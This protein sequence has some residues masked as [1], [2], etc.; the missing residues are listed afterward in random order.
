MKTT[1]TKINKVISLTFFTFYLS[2]TAIFAQAPEKMTY[3]AVIRNASNQLVVNT[4]IGMQISILQTSASGTAVYVETQTQSTNENGVVTLEIGGGNV[5]SGT[6]ANIDWANGIYFIKTE[7]DIVGGTNYTITATSQLLSVPYALYAKTAGT[8]TSGHYVGE[9][10]G[11]GIVFWV[12]PDGQHGLIA[13]LNDLDG[14]SGYIWSNVDSIA[15]GATAQS[16]WDGLSNS[17]A[18]ISQTN[19]T[20]SAA[21]LCLDYS[22]DGFDDW[23][24]P[25]LDE[26]NLIYNV[27][28][29]INKTLES[30]IDNT[31]MGLVHL[32]YW[33]STEFEQYGN[34]KYAFGWDISEGYP[35]YNNMGLKSDLFKVRAI[36]KF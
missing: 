29:M 4:P 32:A 23:Y 16:L 9:L 22:N 7:T 3:Q 8:T 13:S 11:G 30:D 6:F 10:F 19:H 2:L 25:A 1:I 14:G 24:L 28:Y 27:R 36:R 31:T 21:K 34:G 15:I 33:S 35:W 20:T 18:I 12:S 26:I 17:N 5:V